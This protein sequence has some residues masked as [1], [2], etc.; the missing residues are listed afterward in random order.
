MG[1]DQL[2]NT[3]LDTDLDVKTDEEEVL[4][5]L[6][7]GCPPRQESL[8]LLINLPE[9]SMIEI[10][11]LRLNCSI[12]LFNSFHISGQSKKSGKPFILLL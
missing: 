3:G 11:I 7:L 12:F 5:Y 6:S 2:I 8:S 1:D 10:A 9:D 4:G